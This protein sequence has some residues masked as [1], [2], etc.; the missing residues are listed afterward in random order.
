MAT[1]S[2][3]VAVVEQMDPGAALRRQEDSRHLE[4]QADVWS[5]EALSGPDQPVQ[6]ES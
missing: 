3:P 4:W 6:K 1:E 5:E 2:A